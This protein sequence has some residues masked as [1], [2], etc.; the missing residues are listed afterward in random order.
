MADAPSAKDETA[1][2]VKRTIL[3]GRNFKSRFNEQE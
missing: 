2:A 3:N 1:A